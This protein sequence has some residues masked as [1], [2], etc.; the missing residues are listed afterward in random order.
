MSS[1][2]PTVRRS[3][4]ITTWGPGALIDL[5]RHAGIVGSLEVW[6]NIGGLEEI[7]DQRVTQKLAL[8]MGI[9]A[10]KLYAPPPDTSTPG[11]K[12]QGIGVRRFPQ[13]FLVQEKSASGSSFLSR[14]LV[15]HK[16]L[17]ERWRFEWRLVQS[18]IRP[19][20]V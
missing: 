12:D 14:R 17:D 11:E 15:Q 19:S 13:W 8:V 4:V 10:P 3:Q 6:P 18:S 5:P 20:T 7:V 1:K 9:V 16:A 2:Y